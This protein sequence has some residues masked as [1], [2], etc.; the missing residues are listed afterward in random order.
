VVQGI[1][2]WSIVPVFSGMTL[3]Q[4]ANGFRTRLDK[5]VAR[6]EADL[7]T[8]GALGATEHRELVRSFWVNGAADA[9]CGYLDLLIIWGKRHDLT[10]ARSADELVDLTLPDA[11]IMAHWVPPDSTLADIGAGAGAPGLPLTLMRPDV[12]VSLVEPRDKR[13]AFLRTATG[14]LCAPRSVP[15]LRQRSEQLPKWGYDSVVARAVLAPQPWLEHGA[16]LARRAVWVLLAQSEAPAFT[17]F[18]PVV[19]VRYQWPLTGVTRRAVQFE[20]LPA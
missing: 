3:E 1:A 13:V 19:D 14:Q 9:L 20:R 5:S 11:W 16:T 8:N 18:Q 7:S 2:P 12:R 4:P 15:V 10:A 17:G 6:L